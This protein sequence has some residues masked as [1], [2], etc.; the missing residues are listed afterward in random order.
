MKPAT[1]PRTP[2]PA[3]RKPLVKA[4]NTEL[5]GLYWRVGDYIFSLGSRKLRQWCDILELYHQWRHNYGGIT[6]SAH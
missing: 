6:G 3:R 5:T 1:K 2:K 4:V